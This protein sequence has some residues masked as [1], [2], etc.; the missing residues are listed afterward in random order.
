[1]SRATSS[2]EG[3]AKEE[4]LA[5]VLRTKALALMLVLLLEVGDRDFFIVFFPVWCMW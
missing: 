4:T 5:I 3:R 1:M 2:S